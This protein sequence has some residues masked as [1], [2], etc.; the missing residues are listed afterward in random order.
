MHA[1]NFGQ[2]EWAQVGMCDYARGLIKA[3]VYII[4]IYKRGK[5]ED[6]YTG[7]GINGQSLLELC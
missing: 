7:P 6:F 1:M 3:S 2:E 5:K 4:Y